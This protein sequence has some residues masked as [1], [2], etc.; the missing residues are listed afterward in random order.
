LSLPK[1]NF[2]VILDDFTEPGKHFY[3]VNYVDGGADRFPGCTGLLNWIGGVKTKALMW[4]AS[5]QASDFFHHRA[6]DF[7]ETKDRDLNCE[8]YF[9]A[10]WAEAYRMHDQRK[11]SAAD[12]GTTF[13]QAAEDIVNRRVVKRII[14]ADM[15][16]H[17]EVFREWWKGAGLDVVATEVAVANPQLGYG[18]TFDILARRQDSGAYVLGDWK[19]SGQLSDSYGAQLCANNAALVATYNIG[20]EEM[21]ALRL[22]REDGKLEIKWVQDHER[23]F[24]IFKSCLNMEK[25]YRPGGREVKLLA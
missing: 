14:P 7:I 12:W 4:W 13:H 24:E 23:G 16:E 10:A 18:C 17:L 3:V 5:R 21:F 15:M 9:D 2:K 11:D 22:G 19:T 25:A 20:A 1:A 6:L 8:G